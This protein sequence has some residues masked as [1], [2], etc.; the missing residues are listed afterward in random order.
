VR[1]P[2]DITKQG[3]VLDPKTEKDTPKLILTSKK[4]LGRCTERVVDD[5]ETAKFFCVTDIPLKDLPS[6]APYYGKFTIG[7]K[8]SAVHK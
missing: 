8:A 5:L 2:A 1:R 6:H 4:L 7:F 3:L